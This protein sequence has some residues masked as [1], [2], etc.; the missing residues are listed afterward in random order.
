MITQTDV[1]IV[2]KVNGKLQ[3]RHPNG[4][5]DWLEDVLPE[6]YAL[7]NVG[8]PV[9]LCVTSERNFEDRPL[10]L[11]DQLEPFLCSQFKFGMPQTVLCLGLLATSCRTIIRS[12][13]QRMSLHS[14]TGSLG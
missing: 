7:V 2:Q 5:L 13:F 12:L 11:S 6:M 8:I 4:F 10:R 3:V 14:I 9:Q 1:V